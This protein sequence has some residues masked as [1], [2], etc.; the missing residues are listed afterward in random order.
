MAPHGSNAER[1]PS[2]TSSPVGEHQGQRTMRIEYG[3]DNESLQVTSPDPAEKTTERRAMLIPQTPRPIEKR[4]QRAMRLALF[5]SSFMMMGIGM[6]KMKRSK[7]RFK[8]LV[9]YVNATL[10]TH[11]AVAATFAS[12]QP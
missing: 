9:E 5:T 1:M 8:M 3:I 4:R 10:S 11:F 6:E 12:H 7:M 2:G